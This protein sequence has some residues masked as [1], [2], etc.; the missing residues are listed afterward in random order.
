MAGQEHSDE[1]WLQLMAEEPRLIRR[2]ILRTDRGAWV[3]FTPEAWE[4]AV[5]G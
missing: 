5:Q 4:Q 3:G 1:E 2:P